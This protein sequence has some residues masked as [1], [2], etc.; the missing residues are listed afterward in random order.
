[1]FIMGSLVG[2]YVLYFMIG[3]FL[4]V[5]T[6]IILIVVVNAFG[7]SASNWMQSQFLFVRYKW[8]FYVRQRDKSHEW[9]CQPTKFLPP[10]VERHEIML[11]SLSL[12]CVSILTGFI[13]WYAANDGKYL[14]I[15]YKFDEYGWIWLFLQIPVTFMIQVSQYWKN[16]PSLNICY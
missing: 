1:M 7:W 15:Y 14:T 10:D 2:S 11:G 9:K 4:H 6:T 13:A 3:G 8:Y 16:E 12:F 5:N